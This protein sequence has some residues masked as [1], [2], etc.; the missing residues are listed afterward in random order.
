M[1]LSHLY[2]LTLL[3][4]TVFSRN[5]FQKS[6]RIPI[7]YLIAILFLRDALQNEKEWLHNLR[8]N[9]ISKRG[10][11]PWRSAKTSNRL[12]IKACSFSGVS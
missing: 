11:F 6:N 12:L 7:D 9:N 2:A 8:I 1:L 3:H 10:Q 4:S 5:L